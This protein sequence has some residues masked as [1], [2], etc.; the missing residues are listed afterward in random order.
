M[1]M[2]KGSIVRPIANL[3]PA[4]SLMS[5]IRPESEAVDLA[6]KTNDSHDLRFSGPQPDLLRFVT[7]IV[8]HIIMLCST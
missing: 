5:A 3:M 8:K 6:A 7:R 4:L 1:L 2:A